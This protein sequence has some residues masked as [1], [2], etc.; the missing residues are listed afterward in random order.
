MHQSW[1]TTIAGAAGILLGVLVGAFGVLYDQGSYIPVGLGLVTTG[2]GL[3][4]ARD[5]AA[6]E[7]DR[8]QGRT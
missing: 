6:H 8:Q 7:A 1:R 2:A 5:Q 4:Y 3:L